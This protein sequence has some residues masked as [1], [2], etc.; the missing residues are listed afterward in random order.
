MGDSVG[1]EVGVE[2]GLGSDVGIIVLI[3]AV[4]VEKTEL[5]S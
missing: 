3:K 5:V 4:L 2:V 1:V